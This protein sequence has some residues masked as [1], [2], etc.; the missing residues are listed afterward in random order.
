MSLFSAELRMLLLSPLDSAAIL[1]RKVARAVAHG[2]ATGLVAG[3]GLGIALYRID[4]ASP[5]AV[6]AVLA[7][8]GLLA[9]LTYEAA[10]ALCLG[11]GVAP[12]V[13]LGLA[14]ALGVAGSAMFLAGSTVD[15]FSLAGR[16]AT[17]PLRPFTFAFVPALVVVAGLVVGIALA[18]RAP[19]EKVVAH[20]ELVSRLRFALGQ[21]DIRAVV[22]INRALAEDGYRSRLRLKAAWKLFR[23][24]ATV[25]YARSLVNLFGWSPRRYVRVVAFSF[26]ALWLA[27]SAWTSSRSIY[28]AAIPLVMLCGVELADVVSVVVEKPDRFANFPVEDGWLATRLALVPSLAAVVLFLAEVPLVNALVPQV[29]VQVLAA[30]AFSMGASSVLAGAVVSARS[31]SPV[32]TLGLLGPEAQSFGLFLEAVPVVLASAWLAPA[33]SSQGAAAA[34]QLPETDAISGAAFSLIGPLLAWA[35]LRQHSVLKPEE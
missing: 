29:P 8:F 15:P 30:I 10:A 22:L 5:L 31:A 27:A 20:S 17:L 35:W 1:R 12:R 32:G 18:G 25:P 28:L 3:A 23:T 14:A 21:R 33:L 7:G 2:A 13:G 26:G 19:L 11:L 4:P 6:P 9:A 34:G 16:I 24:P